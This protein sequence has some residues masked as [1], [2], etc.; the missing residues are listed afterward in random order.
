LDGP[1][2]ITQVK[3]VADKILK[4]LR[5]PYQLSKQSINVTVSIGSSLYPSDG[6]SVESLLEHA[7]T[8]M[9]RAKKQGRDRLNMNVA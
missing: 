4:A 2:Q 3:A 5:K 1:A 6:Q 9:Y 8:A 7:D